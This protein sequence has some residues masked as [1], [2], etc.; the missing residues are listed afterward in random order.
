MKK[1]ILIQNDGE[2][3][4]NSFELI[5]A[6][7][8][9][10]DDTKIGFFGSGLKYSIA[11][12]MRNNIS[13][14][15]FSG[16]KELIFTTVPEKLKDQ[17]FNRICIN[18]K[19]TSYTTT[20]GPTWTKDWFILREIYCNAL[21]ESNCQ[22]IREITDINPVFGK[23]RI[24]IELTDSLRKVSK[25]WDN[26][27]SED[28]VP[29]KSLQKVYTSFLSASSSYQPIQ[30]YEKTEGVLYRKGIRV[31]IEEGLLYDYGFDSADIN[32]DRT[33]K[34]LNALPYAFTNL[35]AGFNS[36]NYVLSI[37]RSGLE[38]HPC[39]EYRAIETTKVSQLFSQEWIELSKNYFLV[40]AERSGKYSEE[41]SLTKK[42]VLLVPQLFA[43]EL[44]KQLPEV[45]I[46]GIGRTLGELEMIDVE[47]T[48][49]MN[50]LLK[51]V[52]KSLNEMKYNVFSLISIVEFDDSIILGSAN[53]ETKHIYLSKKLFDMGRR[54]L[55][56]TIMEENEHIISGKKDETRAFQ[57]HLFSSWL[58]TM[59]DFN[60]L[61]L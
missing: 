35:M 10:D 6:S 59:E 36:E 5:G 17:D 13:F 51:D 53:I 34:K 14:K 2:I 32:E 44:K 18:N 42:E 52:L 48:P 38:E 20:M 24:Y 54:E 12:M 50:Y 29:I 55:A 57:N 28:R 3:E 60:G 39:S 45:I 30:I 47:T 1:Y 22:I 23:T 43:K 61:F 40:V 7:T 25:E 16:E 33:A 31:G 58:R 15:V 8:K 26:Y 27:F 19:P 49:K 37:L 11:Y 41:I 46:T 9:R 56:L 4:S 21:D